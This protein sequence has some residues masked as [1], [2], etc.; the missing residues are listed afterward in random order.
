MKNSIGSLAALA[1]FSAP[2]LV[3]AV[4]ADPDVRA[5]SFENV[6]LSYSNANQINFDIDG[7]G[8]PDFYVYGNSGINLRVGVLN[9]TEITASPVTF[10]ADFDLSEASQTFEET[11]SPSFD[12][13]YGFDFV[14]TFDS[15][16]HAAW[17]RFN[18]GGIDPVAVNGAWQAG[19]GYTALTVGAIP[20]P[21]AF[22]ALA[23][24]V[25]LIGTL[26]VRRR[27]PN[28]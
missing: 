17:V 4:P 20:E 25:A 11:L 27:R 10:G 12:G 8:T 22:G 21:S 18:L 23:G 5:A 16:H 9:S 7:D 6:T 1:A 28:P 19:P 26:A 24:A 3:H 2:A 13:Y 14:S 15:E